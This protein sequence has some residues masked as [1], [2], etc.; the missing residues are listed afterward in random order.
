MGAEA[1][2]K[3]CFGRLVSG[4]GRRPDTP[5]VRLDDLN[6]FS[7]LLPP[8]LTILGFLTWEGEV[9]HYLGSVGARDTGVDVRC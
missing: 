1:A 5:P 3:S 7:P 8:P 9:S 2:L 6:P 4:K